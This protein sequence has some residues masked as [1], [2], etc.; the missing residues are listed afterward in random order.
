VVAASGPGAL[1][2]LACHR[3]RL[4]GRLRTRRSRDSLTFPQRSR[5]L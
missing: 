1:P 3:A 2:G 5:R 4:L